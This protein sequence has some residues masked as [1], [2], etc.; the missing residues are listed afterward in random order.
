[1]FNSVKVRSI[2]NF[3]E[4]G[5]RDPKFEN[6]TGIVESYCKN[7]YNLEYNKNIIEENNKALDKVNS[8][9]DQEENCKKEVEMLVKNYFDKIRET[10]TD[11]IETNKKLQEQL[12]N[13]EEVKV[14]YLEKKT[15]Y[16]NY[17]EISTIDLKIKVID[18][19]TKAVVRQDVWFN[20]SNNLLTTYKYDR[21]INY[22]KYKDRTNLYDILKELQDNKEFDY[23]CINN[24]LT[25]NKKVKENF[26]TLD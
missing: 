14:L 7:L 13:V 16:E 3:I 22:I 12:N 24:N 10:K 23:I 18:K 5:L 21:T 9:L 19:N 6:L 15:K 25:V 26:K 1:M 4:I 2:D 20:T 11:I 17:R 8:I